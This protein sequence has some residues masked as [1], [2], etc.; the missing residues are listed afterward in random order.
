M[1]IIFLKIQINFDIICLNKI[2][3]QQIIYLLY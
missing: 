3:K 1:N 2:E